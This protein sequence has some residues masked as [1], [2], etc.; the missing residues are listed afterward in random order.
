[1]AV[2]TPTQMNRYPYSVQRMHLF[3]SNIGYKTSF[4]AIP[5]LSYQVLTARANNNLTEQFP[6]SL[7]QRTHLLTD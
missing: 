6:N 3:K 7:T 2:E 4:K 1:M 5:D